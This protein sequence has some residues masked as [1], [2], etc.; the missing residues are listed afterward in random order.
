VSRTAAHRNPSFIACFASLR[1]SA[2]LRAFVVSALSAIVGLTLCFVPGPAVAQLTAPAADPAPE[3]TAKPAAKPRAAKK[4]PPRAKAKSTPPRKSAPPK[5]AP[6]PRPSAPARPAR[7]A[8]SSKPPA[9]P[10]PAPIRP[11]QAVPDRA[12]IPSVEAGAPPEPGPGGGPKASRLD[13]REAEA[14]YREAVELERQGDLTASFTAFH[15]SAEAGFGLAQKKLGDL[16]GTG[17]D[18]VLRDYETSL[19]WYRKAREQGIHV[20]KPFTYPGIR[21]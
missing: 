9:K 13:R 1:V 2:K 3:R 10:Q 14:R 8:T 17:N 20:P 12:P 15:E 7:R 16:Y 18:A 11:S 6:K 4:P 5:A 19:R 21:R